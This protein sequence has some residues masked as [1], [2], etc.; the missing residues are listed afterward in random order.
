MPTDLEAKLKAILKREEQDRPAADARV[1]AAL[2]DP[3][4]RGLV[5]RAT[6]RYA[7]IFSDKGMDLARRTLAV[8]FTTDP[9]AMALLEKARAEAASGAVPAPG[10]APKSS[11]KKAE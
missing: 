7:R 1:E 3:V 6:A 10:A 8:Y 4:L 11:A 5:D 9:G 2:A